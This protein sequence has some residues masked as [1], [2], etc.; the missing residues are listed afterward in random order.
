M[1]GSRPQPRPEAGTLPGR[2]RAL[3]HALLSDASKGL[4][5]ADLLENACRALADF[6]LCDVAEIYLQEAVG[7]PPRQAGRHIVGEH[8]LQGEESPG[9]TVS[10]PDL[11]ARETIPSHFVEAVIK[12]EFGAAPPFY[13]RGG[14]FWTGDATRPILVRQLSPGQESAR[15]IVLGGDFLSIALVPIPMDLKTSGAL[16]LGS[17]KRDHISREDVR[18]YEAAAETLGIALAHHST[19]WALKER[20]KELSCLYG[21][22]QILQRQDLGLDVLLREIVGLLPP[23]WQY[24]EVTRA[25]I[26]LDGRRFES[27]G[28]TEGPVRMTADI[29]ING[30]RRGLVEVLYADH[31]PEDFEGPFLREERNLINAVADML[32]ISLGHY[33]TQWKLQERVK[34]LTCLYGIA[35]IARQPGIALPEALEQIASVLPP[36][37]QYPE[38]TAA[39][40]TLD[41][42]VFTTPGFRLASQL[43]SSEIIV[44]GAERGRVELVYTEHQPPADKGPF[45]AE[46]RNLIE[47]VARQVALIVESQEAQEEKERLQ[48]QLRHADR[49]ATIGQLSAGAAHE[50][51]EPLGNILGF[52]QLAMKC[53]RLPK[54]AGQDLD[55]IVT[56]ALHAREVVK[57]LM[58]FARQEPPKKSRIDLNTLLRDGLYFIESRCLREGIHLVFQLSEKMPNV[59]ADPSQIHQVLINLVVNAIQAMPG[60]GTL[61]ISTHADDRLVYLQIRDTGVGMSPETAKQIFTPFFTTKGVGQG[62]GLGLSVVHGILADHGGSVEVKSALGKGS[63]FEVRL[64]IQGGPT[65]DRSG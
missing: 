12:G 1:N 19:Q 34:E 21:I 25:R 50:L 33:K 5:R 47:E 22:A 54:Q 9:G 48:D 63:C 27:H 10:P 17:L 13:T 20:V 51:N 49:L 24:P 18:F 58:L 7:V 41:D 62:T 35:N 3:V 6:S 14:S 11:P 40:I 39:R 28:F 4:P 56:A 65:G 46:E 60:G 42:L 53:P 30:E 29:V 16:F 31:R 23:G 37:W 52:A 59:T 2:F 15:G 38:A 64:P 36:G 55:K 26:T 44:N 61:T 32:G 8:R 57:K 43:M 45:L